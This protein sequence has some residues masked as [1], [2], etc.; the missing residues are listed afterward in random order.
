MQRQTKH[1]QPN[2]KKQTNTIHNQHCNRSNLTLT[3][4]QS[5][6]TKI[7]N[8]KIDQQT[9]VTN[10]FVPKNVIYFL[11]FKCFEFCRRIQ[12]SLIFFV[13]SLCVRFFFLFFFPHSSL[14]CGIFNANSCSLSGLALPLPSINVSC[15]ATLTALF[16][17]RLLAFADIVFV[18]CGPLGTLSTTSD[19]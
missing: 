6:I 14:R 16:V 3:N 2:K 4:T 5:T 8:K 15:A 12:I 10:S 18:F 9:W 7:K 13:S 11:F 1:N 17:S 19:D